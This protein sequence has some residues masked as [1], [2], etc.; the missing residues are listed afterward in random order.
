MFGKQ[1]WGSAVV[2]NAHGWA[3]ISQVETFLKRS[4]IDSLKSADHEHVSV[5]PL[6]DVRCPFKYR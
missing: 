3:T 6:I 4:A 2:D 1:G 5:S